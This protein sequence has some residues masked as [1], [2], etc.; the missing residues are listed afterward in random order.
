MRRGRF[1]LIWFRHRCYNPGHKIAVGARRIRD[2]V[3]SVS[4]LGI[5]SDVED[6]IYAPVPEVRGAEIRQ[7][8]HILFVNGE[9]V[10]GS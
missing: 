3:I 6:D 9:H 5:R 2:G 7:G 10:G 1:G 8:T 4:V